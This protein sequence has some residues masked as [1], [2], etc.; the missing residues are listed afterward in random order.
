MWPPRLPTG[1]CSRRACSV[2]AGS[3][4]S[5]VSWT[6]A[7]ARRSRA[8][9][10]S[11]S[12]TPKRTFSRS[13]PASSTG[14]CGWKATGPSGGRTQ[15]ATQ[16]TSRRSAWSSEDLPEP[17]APATS[18]SSP[19]RGLKST[20]ASTGGPPVSHGSP[21]ASS[22]ALSPAA[23][24]QEKAPPPTQARWPSSA[25]ASGAVSSASAPAASLAGNARLAWCSGSPRK[26]ST[27]SASMC[28]CTQQP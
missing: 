24:D 7:R 22:A 6:A 19:L 28:T 17:T 20:P 1:V 21:A 14:A 3:S 4:M 16:G 18:T 2:L 9:S 8:S 13:V 15:P 5:A 10:H 12:G 11:A 23:P 25:S 27:L 26:A